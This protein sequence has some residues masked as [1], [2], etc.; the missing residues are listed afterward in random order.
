MLRGA[1]IVALIVLAA[2]GQ[3]SPTPRV[4]PSVPAV[5]ASWTQDL[6]FSGDLSGHMA[7]IVTN[8]DTQVSACTGAKPRPG[9]NWSDKFYGTIDPSGTV[10]GVYFVIQNFGGAGTYQSSAIAVQV[11]SLDNTQLWQNGGSDAVT[12]TLD[13]SGESGTIDAML[14]NAESGKA[15]ALHLTGHWNCRA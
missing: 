10:W 3:S 4:S 6:T 11:D 14:T 8:T 12:F 5:A 15:G 9:Q 7:G 2:C 1:G 13:R